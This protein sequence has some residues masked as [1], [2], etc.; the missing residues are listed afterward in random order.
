[1]DLLTQSFYQTLT[2]KR[3]TITSYGTSDSYD[4]SPS[5]ETSADLRIGTFNVRVF[6]LNKIADDD[7]LNLLVRVCCRSLI[8]GFVTLQL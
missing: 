4:T 1:M 8:R 7:V 5:N 2:S 6:G 3:E